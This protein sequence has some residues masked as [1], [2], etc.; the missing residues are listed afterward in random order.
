VLVAY[1]LK[2]INVQPEKQQFLGNGCV[3][4]NNGLT[5]GSGDFYAVR[6]KAIYRGSDA[7]LGTT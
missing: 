3:T 2:A 5:V 7:I 1:L 4:R 6:A